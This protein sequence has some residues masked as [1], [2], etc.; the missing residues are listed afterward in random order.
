M[1]VGVEP[2]GHVEGRSAVDSA[3]HGEH[4][5]VAGLQVAVAL[6]HDAEPLGPAPSSM[7]GETRCYAT[8]QLCTTG[9]ELDVE[10]FCTSREKWIRD[11]S[12]WIERA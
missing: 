8:K 6:G 3:C 12:M 1:V 5:L 7:C 2:L 10:T 11:R 4:T 9:E